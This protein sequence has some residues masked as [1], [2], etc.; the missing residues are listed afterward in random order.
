[1]LEKINEKIDEMKE[2][3]SSYE[4][5]IKSFCDSKKANELFENNDD[6]IAL[7]DSFVQKKD[8]EEDEYF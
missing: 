4:K 5:Y 6:F 2:D 8:K 3:K 1:M 7:K